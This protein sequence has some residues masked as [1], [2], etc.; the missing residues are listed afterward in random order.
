SSDFAV[1][2]ADDPTC[3]AL[4]DKVKG[5]L[6][7]FSR[8]QRIE[9]GA[10]VQ[11]DQIMFR[12]NGQEQ[13]V[14]SRSDIQLK[15]EHNL[16]NVLAAVA[17]TMVAGCTPQQVRHAVKEFRAVEHRLELAATINSVTFYNDSKATNVDATMKALES[18][19]ANIHI[20]L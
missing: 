7:W 5:S 20:I 1:L 13:P 12:H 4:K 2:N 16:E 11:G 10:F 18:F 14:L 9:N 17:M 15:G 19:P 3:V 8:K 6:L